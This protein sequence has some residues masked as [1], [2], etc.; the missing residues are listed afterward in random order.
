MALSKFHLWLDDP[1]QYLASIYDLHLRE[2]H[3]VRTMLIER[4]LNVAKAAAAVAIGEEAAGAREK[5]RKVAQEL[6]KV[7]IMS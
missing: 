6:C 1:T 3:R 7:L 4:R 5:V 2:A